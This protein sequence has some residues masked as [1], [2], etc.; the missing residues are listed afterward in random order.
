[1]TKSFRD[2]QKKDELEWWKT[3]P[4]L[5]E[6]SDKNGKTIGKLVLEKDRLRFKGKADES[7][8]LLMEKLKDYI[9]DF[10]RFYSRQQIEKIGKEFWD[11]CNAEPGKGVW[12]ESIEEAIERITGVKEPK[13]NK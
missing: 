3:V 9:T 11:W 10:L 1:M 2:K 5:I 12:I 8:R 7:A 6:F 13:R 4:A